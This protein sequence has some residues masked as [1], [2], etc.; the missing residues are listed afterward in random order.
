MPPF[1]IIFF[2]FVFAFVF[3]FVFVFIFDWPVDAV[4]KVVVH[5]PVVLHQVGHVALPRRVVLRFALVGRL[6]HHPFATAFWNLKD[7][8]TRGGRVWDGEDHLNWTGCLQNLWIVFFSEKRGIKNYQNLI[9]E[10]ISQSS[11]RFEE[12]KLLVIITWSVRWADRK[13]NSHLAKADIVLV[14]TADKFFIQAYV[15]HN[16]RHPWGRVTGNRPEYEFIFREL[17]KVRHVICKFGFRFSFQGL[18]S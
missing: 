7:S 6:Q 12:K 11:R 14:I 5:H 8:T 1:N 10:M 3:I 2:K 13:P 17:H 15:L 4:S 9:L 18:T 16:L